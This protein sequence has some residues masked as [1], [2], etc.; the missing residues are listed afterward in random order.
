MQEPQECRVTQDP[1]DPGGSLEKGVSRDYLED[2]VWRAGMPVT[3]T[4]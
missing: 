4:L 2:K 3:N 1:Q